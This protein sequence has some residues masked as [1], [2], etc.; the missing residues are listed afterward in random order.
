M[1]RLRV[2][3]WGAR[4]PGSNRKEPE[5]RKNH[6]NRSSKAMLV[7]TDL[8]GTKTR[9]RTSERYVFQDPMRFQAKPRAKVRKFVGPILGGGPLF[10]QMSRPETDSDLISAIRW[11]LRQ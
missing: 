1:R 8:N 3:K 6:I 4:E 5:N 7:I 9:H 10:R 2:S 11:N